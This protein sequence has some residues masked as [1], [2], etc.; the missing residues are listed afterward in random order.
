M[1]HLAKTNTITSG[2]VLKLFLG[3]L[4]FHLSSF[5]VEL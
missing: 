5:D 4:M 3:I 1:Q 2:Y